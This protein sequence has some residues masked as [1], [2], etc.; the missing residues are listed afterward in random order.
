[1]AHLEALA[2]VTTENMLNY[3]VGFI[4]NVPEPSVR[5]VDD[6]S[7]VSDTVAVAVAVTLD[8]L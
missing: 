8:L 7:L 2:C 1:M 3:R 4:N 5:G 6:P